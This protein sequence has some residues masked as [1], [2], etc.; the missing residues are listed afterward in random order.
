MKNNRLLMCMPWHPL[1]RKA[2][3]AGF[4]VFSIWDPSL[5]S[6]EYLA[7]V[8]KFSET[9][10][11]TDFGDQEGL[12]RL[13]AEMAVRYDPAHVLHLGAEATQLAVCEQAAAMGLALNSPHSLAQINDKAAMRALLGARGISPV[14]STEAGSPAEAEQILRERAELPVVVKPTRLDGSRAVRLIERPGDIDGWRRELASLGYR[15]HVL[16][17]E[18]LRGPEFSVETIT[19]HGTH[20]VVGITAKRLGRRP[21]FVEMGHVHPAPITAEVRTAITDL[22]I[23]FLEATGYRFGPVHTEVILTAAGPRIVESQARLGGDRIPLLVELASG[24][25]MEA[26]VFT[27]LAGGP[28]EPAPATRSAAISFFD[29]GTGHVRSIE[30][31][32][33]VDRLP[34][35]HALKLKVAPGDALTP[36]RSS[37]TRHGYVVVAAAT[38]RQADEHLA[39]ARARLSVVTS[40]D[41]EPLARAGHRTHSQTNEKAKD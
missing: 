21:H 6:A 39:E 32:G 19:A 26:A 15:D 31:A 4:R 8:A 18:Y 7:E 20:H 35:V 10:V 16:I 23:A 28:V 3:A 12:R 22:V 24:F 17:E 13:V 25:D 30:G 37:S 33:D 29:F 9:M 40:P 41:G 36:V 11:L 34:F 27:A 1:V 2:A 5:E 14:T 38:E